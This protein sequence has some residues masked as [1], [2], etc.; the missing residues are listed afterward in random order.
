MKQTQL[1]YL[2]NQFLNNSRFNY[3]FDE[4]NK[5]GK[6]EL[7]SFT[8]ALYQ[9][10]EKVNVAQSD[11]ELLTHIKSFREVYLTSFK[12]L[13]DMK[14]PI[15]EQLGE[16]FFSARINLVDKWYKEETQLYQDKIKNGFFE[17]FKSFFA[18]SPDNVLADEGI[19]EK[20]QKMIQKYNLKAI[21]LS[22]IK[23][24][25]EAHQYLDKVDA[26][27]EDVC[28]RLGVKTK[29]IGLNRFLGLAYGQ[30]ASYNSENRY[31]TTATFRSSKSSLLHE[32]I[33][34]LDNYIG[35][36]ITDNQHTYATGYKGVA[37]V[38]DDSMNQAFHTM[39]KLTVRMFNANP[40]LA[41]NKID[42]QLHLGS[43]KFLSL[44]IGSKWY[45]LDTEDRKKLLTPEIKQAI[46]NYISHYSISNENAQKELLGKI[47][48]TGIIS[49]E[50]LDKNLQEQQE[51]IIK[52]V[53]PYYQK[54]NEIM[55]TSPSA[56]YIGSKLTSWNV[57]LSKYAEKTLASIAK[58]TG[59]IKTT[60]NSSNLDDKDY[61][62]NPLEMT[63]R[64][65]ESQ[66]YPVASQI[67]NVSALGGIYKFTK[68]KEFEEIK[69]T[70][71]TQALGQDIL[72]EKKNVKVHDSENAMSQ[73]LNIRKQFYQN[74]D[75]ENTM[76]KKP[77]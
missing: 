56:Y 10:R 1:E 65:F 25:K 5:F 45:G 37:P 2:K 46:N 6:T 29:A 68:D 72:V 30:G 18:S 19:Q 43:T 69:N 75:N 54:M 4:S 62:T 16:Y 8:T 38:V 15:K 35:M 3:F 70:L 33:H 14:H 17:K 47:A 23:G 11:D 32:W 52:E 34:A 49:K 66:V 48:Q 50:Q 39:K 36:D 76:T 59:K 53:K 57:V 73:I 55:H 44:A 22:E 42:D 20:T 28:A 9:V 7:Q 27:F 67:A 51:A 12:A 13:R 74:H 60:R 26:N 71:L 61:F 58:L 31:I 40:E 63:A 24:I 77:V 21:D 41:Q 64:Y